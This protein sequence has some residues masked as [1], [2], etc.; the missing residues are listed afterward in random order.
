M[1]KLRKYLVILLVIAAVII[2][3]VF[4]LSNEAAVALNLIFYITPPIPVSLL[5]L[6]A[7]GVGLLLGIVVTGFA[8]LKLKVAGRRD[9]SP[10]LGQS[11]ANNN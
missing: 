2:G 10:R 11:V 4:A 7:F 3:V 8:V 1:A 9:R 5:V 6:G